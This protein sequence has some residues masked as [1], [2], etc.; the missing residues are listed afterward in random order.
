MCVCVCVC[1]C[2]LND[3]ASW[4]MLLDA[5]VEMLAFITCVGL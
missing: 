1:V 2:V 3:G 4:G 5:G